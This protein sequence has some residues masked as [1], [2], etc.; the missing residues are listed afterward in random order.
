MAHG[1]MFLTRCAI[2]PCR[3]QA[4]AVSFKKIDP[5]GNPPYLG[6]AACA[7][8]LPASGGAVIQSRR[9]LGASCP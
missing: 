6:A 2:T 7:K 5:P 8:A 3:C 1:F 4:C 9:R